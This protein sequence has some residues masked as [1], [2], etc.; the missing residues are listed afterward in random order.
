MIDKVLIHR[1]RRLGERGQWRWQ[2][3]AGGNHRKLASGGESYHNLED[4]LESLASV[5]DLP[6]EN[7]LDRFAK[8]EGAIGTM[9][10]KGNY[11]RIR[12]E[13]RP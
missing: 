13:V 8:A 2:Y 4:L 9:Y 5:L 7:A 6:L 1:S 12:I 10:R 11:E 3:L